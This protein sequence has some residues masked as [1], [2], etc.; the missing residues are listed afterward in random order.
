M[1]IEKGMKRS[2]LTALYKLSLGSSFR[3]LVCFREIGDVLVRT[4]AVSLVF[5][6]LLYVRR[7]PLFFLSILV[8]LEMIYKRDG[9]MAILILSFI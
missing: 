3:R 9:G 2:L 5:Y 4:M 6:F 8:N 1:L 7:I